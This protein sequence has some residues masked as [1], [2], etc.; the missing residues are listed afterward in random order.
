[1]LDFSTSEF[2]P[3]EITPT[4]A[5]KNPSP[6][7]LRL[8]EFLKENYGRKIISGTVANVSW[9]TNEAEWVYHHTGKY[10]ALNAFD[11]IFLFASPANWI[12]YSH[13]QVVEDWWNR[14]GIVSG[15]WHWNVPK[16]PGSTDYSF[17]TEETNFDIAKAVTSGT[18][19]NQII[20]ADLEKISDYL[21]LLK[22]KNIP[23]LWRPLHEAKGNSGKYPG[24]TAWFWWGAKGA[25]P[26]KTLWRLMFDCFKEKGLNNLIW[27]W[28]SETD[29]DDWYPGDDYVDIVGRDMYN[30]T[31]AGGM[32][33]EYNT[34]KKQYPGKIITLS[35]CGNVASVSAQWNA[36]AKW[37]WF[38]SWYD[39]ERTNNPNSQ[40]FNELSHEHL[41]IASWKSAFADDK[42]IS[43]DQMP[44][45]K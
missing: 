45:L 40:A 14:R 29:D 25:T 31:D 12:D 20:L 10:P 41:N 36:G 21:L 43:R 18:S 28:T 2:P 19:E 32:L 17:Y 35:E 1:R 27:V 23:V 16:R 38:M 7:A 9:N 5:I 30:L 44:D 4:L 11:Y 39:Y 6:E 8:Y 24:G 26:F 33:E 3:E 22:Q 13:T 37:S 34:L 15:M 42:V